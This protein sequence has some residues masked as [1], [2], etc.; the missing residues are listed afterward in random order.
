MKRKAHGPEP[1][2]VTPPEFAAGPAAVAE[3]RRQLA[4]HTGLMRGAGALL[5]MNQPG[6][7]DC[8][9]CAWPEDYAAGKRLEF[10]ENGAKAFADQA[11]LKRATPEFFAAHAVAEL[12]RRSGQWLNEQ[13]R[14]TQ[15]M[16]LKPGATHYT[17]ITWFS[18]FELISRHLRGLANPNQAAFYTSGRTSNE[19][20]FLW[21]LFVRAY[22]TNNMPDCSNMCHESSGFA[23]N[24]VIGTGKGTVRLRDFE[25]ADAIFILGQNPGSNHPRMLATLERAKRRGAKIVTVNPLDEA[26]TRQFR[27]PQKLSGLL[28]SGTRLSDLHIPVRVNGDV[29]FLQGLCKA[30]LEAEAAAPGSVLDSAFIERSTTGFADFAAHVAATEW[31][32]IEAVSGVSR[33]AIE[34]AAAVAIQAD[35]TIC[36][37]AMGLT[38]HRNA[39][40]NITEVVNF[41]LL[42]GNFGRPGAGACPVRG[43]SNVQGDRTMGVWE[44]PDSDLLD[45]LSVEFDFVPPAA[46]GLDTVDTLRAMAAGDIKVLVA[47]GGNFVAATPD[48]AYTEAALRRCEL[49]VQISTKLNR[50]H[51]VTG[52]TA[53]ILPVLGSTEQDR[54]P[55]GEQFVTVEN[56]MG[57]VTKSR[58]VLAPASEHLR[59]EVRV[60]AELAESVLGSTSRLNW[61]QLADDYD[62]IRDRIARVIPGFEDFND[63]LDTADELELPNAVRDRGEFPTATG[64]AHFT[65]NSLAAVVVPP[66]HF[67]LTTIRSHDQFNTSVYSVNDRYRG[68]SASRD[69]VLMNPDDMAA[70]G[71][72]AGVRVDVVSGLP[73]DERAVCDLA[74]VPYGIPAGCVAMYYPEANPLVPIS[75]VA[76]GSNT[77]AY[78]SVPVRITRSSP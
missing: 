8:P 12:A 21:Q 46:H 71:L 16:V 30:L 27:N 58:G 28:G 63:V 51:V 11:T 25:R 1:Q 44:K 73:A 53:L 14:I 15:P 32:R 9:G 74:V 41:L 19:A 37:W 22:G 33:A 66:G 56:S 49:T 64:R 61:R 29:A 77:P 20:A 2:V 75:A 65:V 26:G 3:V 52:A 4:A 55:G 68:I 31:S 38:Q 54:Q 42:K 72:A 34:A 45:R 36:C 17:P 39:V 5:K 35:S 76:V 13:G 23:L 59:S 18:A 43:H 6:G 57:V 24:K 67:L 62:R 70:A 60:V 69:V 48:T 78:K 47:M 40:A 50:S 10:C 7:F